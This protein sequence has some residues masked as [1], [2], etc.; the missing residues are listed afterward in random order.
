MIILSISV[1]FALLIFT[2]GCI[3]SNIDRERARK[4]FDQS[5]FDAGKD[6]NNVK[7]R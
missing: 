7:G 5:K 3:I 1:V 4:E 6:R 2:S